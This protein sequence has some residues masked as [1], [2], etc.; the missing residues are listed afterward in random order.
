MQV[1]IVS[2]TEVPDLLPMGEC[3]EVV[4]QA[5]AALAKGDA[6]LPL[7]PV[8]WLP[9]GEGLL[10]MMPAHLGNI[11]SVGA[12]VF[13]VFTGNHG[14]EYDVHQGAVLL[15]ETKNG[16]LKAI[17]D[18]TSITGIRTAAASAVATKLLARPDADDLAILGSGTQ[19]RA[20]L[21]AMLL[22]R[23]IRRVRVWSLP[24]D[25]G[26]QFAERESALHDIPIEAVDTARE[27]VEGAN[28]ICTTTPA[29]EPV[30]MGAWLSPGTHIN[31]VGSS[32]PTTRELD[33]EA[34][35]KS[36]LFVDRCEST[37]NE[38]GDF[39]FPRIE[40]AIND[41]HI[42]G[43]IG[44]IL[45]GK[46]EGRRSPDEITLF[47]SL[48]LAIEDLASAHHVYKK[49]LAKGVGTLVALGGRHHAST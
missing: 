41:D 46:I 2:Q 45:V 48:G 28:L 14:T 32:V 16:C 30:L 26:R 11:Q 47:K 42:L 23:P 25:H 29:R 38:A 40:G 13:S 5:F 7:R 3:I 19:A 27:A 12:K 10:C 8:L 20:H 43:E 1:L 4:E 35:T 15:F 17:V 49:A 37:L 33:T 18:A 21:K 34:V 44:D 9:E 39:I 36:R 24:L 6:V 31:A 22:V